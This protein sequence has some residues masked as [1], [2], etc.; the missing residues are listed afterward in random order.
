MH[1]SAQHPLSRGEY[2]DRDRLYTHLGR[3]LDA[4]YQDGRTVSLAGGSQFC[5]VAFMAV[6]EKRN[7][8]QGCGNTDDPESPLEIYTH[9]STRHRTLKHCM[10]GASLASHKMTLSRGPPRMSKGLITFRAFSR[11]NSVVEE[12]LTTGRVALAMGP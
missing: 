9:K 11:G 10:F 6:R 3:F 1:R 5:I 8:S 4:R 7:R 2:G 12:Y